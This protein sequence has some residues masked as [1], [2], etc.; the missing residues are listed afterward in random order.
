DVALQN[1]GEAAGFF[2]REDRRDVDLGEDFLGAEGVRKQRASLHVFANAV[3]VWPELQVGEALGE[4]VESFQDGQAGADESDELLVE[5]QEF[6]EIETLAATGQMECESTA[7]GFDVVDEE[8][9]ARVAV[10]DFLIGRAL[11]DQVVN[12]T[13]RVGVL[14]LEVSHYCEAS[15]TSAPAGCLKTNRVGAI[16]GLSCS[17]EKAN[18][19]FAFV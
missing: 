10:A 9:L 1:F 17:F 4:E 12:L 5:D 11:D 14:E 13:G 3:D 8:A 18:S 6:F 15:T 2:A 7:F 19:S 16:W